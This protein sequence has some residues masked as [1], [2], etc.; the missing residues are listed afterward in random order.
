M[1]ASRHT[2]VISTALVA[3][4]AV[5]V[6]SQCGPKTTTT[7]DYDVIFEL[8]STSENLTS[9]SFSVEYTG[10][11]TFKGSSSSVSCSALVTT[12]TGSPSFSDNE[13]TDKLTVQIQVD[14]ANAMDADSN[15]VSCV[16]QATVKPTTANFSISVT[17][18]TNTS[19]ASVSPLPEVAVYSISESVSA[20]T[21]TSTS[22][23][24]SSS[25]T[26]STSSSTT[27]G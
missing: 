18:A 8:D 11:G 27:G 26:S 12:A 17:A 10:G 24:S 9:I 6:L 20:S 13:T 25:S 14:T 2:H 4:A 15:I 21:S 3:V 23:S 7:Q 22:S 19:S 1:K 5:F 16:Y